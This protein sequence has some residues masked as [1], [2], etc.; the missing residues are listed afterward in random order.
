MPERIADSPMTTAVVM[1]VAI[2]TNRFQVFF[3][4]ARRSLGGPSSFVRFKLRLFHGPVEFLSVESHHLLVRSGRV[5]GVFFESLSGLAEC[6][7]LS[8]A[9]SGEGVFASYFKPVEVR[10]AAKEKIGHEIAH[11]TKHSDREAN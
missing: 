2:K 4:K 7:S 8:R 10:E 3:E 1:A 6:R 11:D 9:T 5:D